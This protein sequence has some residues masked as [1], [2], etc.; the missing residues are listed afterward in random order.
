MKRRHATHR[1][2][3]ALADLAK[4]YPDYKGQG[5]EIAG[6]AWFE[7]HKD[8]SDVYARH[9]ENNLVK[10]I[11]SLR[12]DYDAPNAKFVLATG[13]G[14]PGRENFGLQ[15]ANARLAMNDTGK[16]PDFVRNVKAVDTRDF[17]R[18]VADS[19]KDQ[20][21]HYN[22]NAETYMEVGFSLGRTMKE[23]LKK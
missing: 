3:T 5:Y 2:A 22:R 16:Y 9:Y 15:T 4:I 7:G 20:C 12:K 1:I 14:N 18:E 23:L 19:P 10:L 6:F 21:F 8:Q 17:W 11:K 13:C